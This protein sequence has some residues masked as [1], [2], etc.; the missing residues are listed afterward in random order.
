[1]KKGH[2]TIENKPSKSDIDNFVK[3]KP[4]GLPEDYVNFISEN[5]YTTGD[6]PLNP[7][8]FRL[9]SVDKVLGVNEDYEIQQYMPNYFGI[10]DQGGG[11]FLAID[12]RDHKIYV[13]P[14]APMDEEDRIFCFENFKE[15]KDN[16][17]FVADEPKP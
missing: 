8:Y 17:G 16:M 6:I 14:F 5:Y 15:F 11:E 3:N 12:L 1:M 10:G 9:W 4:K 2:L 13:I 7:F